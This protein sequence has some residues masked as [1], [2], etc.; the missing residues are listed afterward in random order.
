MIFISEFSL[1]SVKSRFYKS[2]SRHRRQSFFFSCLATLVHSRAIQNCTSRLTRY[3]WSMLGSNN[4]TLVWLKDCRVRMTIQQ[5]TQSSQKHSNLV[6]ELGR[7]S[8]S[9]PCWEDDQYL[10]FEVP[11][12]HSYVMHVTDSGHQLAHDAARL[13]FTEVLLPANS[14]QQLPSTEQLQDQVRVELQANTC[15]KYL[16]S[17]PLQPLSTFILSNCTLLKVMN[18]TNIDKMFCLLMHHQSSIHRLNCYFM[19]MCEMLDRNFPVA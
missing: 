12:H 16:H 7:I 2:N 18:K 14:L 15:G 1:S 5:I 3:S 6:Y 4:S 11:V 10:W 8:S 19:L 17:S 13:R 9:V